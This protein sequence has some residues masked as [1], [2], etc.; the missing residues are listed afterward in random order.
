MS[1]TTRAARR[2]EPA[3]TGRT[4]APAASTYPA[5]RRSQGGNRYQEELTPV[6]RR[7]KRDDNLFRKKVVAAT[8][9]QATYRGKKARAAARRREG[10]AAVTCGE[11]ASRLQPQLT[12]AVAIVVALQWDQA[13]VY[14]L[15]AGTFTDHAPGLVATNAVG[16][17]LYV[18]LL[19]LVIAAVRAGYNARALALIK[20]ALQ[21]LVGWMWRLVVETTDANIG[22]LHLTHLSPANAMWTRFGIV[23]GFA[24]VVA[25][26]LTA[27]LT[28]ILHPARMRPGTSFAKEFAT[29]LLGAGALTI[30]FA[31]HLALVNF[32]LAMVEEGL[33][34]E[35]TR[36]NFDGY[37]LAA[38]VCRAVLV[39]VL[40]G[41]LKAYTPFAHAAR[42]AKPPTQK[43][44]FASSFRERSIFTGA[45]ALLWLVAFSWFA[46]VE[47][48]ADLVALEED[49]WGSYAVHTA[50]ALFFLLCAL[51]LAWRG[52]AVPK[53][54]GAIKPFGATEV[55]LYA[56]NPMLLG[57]GLFSSYTALV[58]RLA[59]PSLG[60]IVFWSLGAAL[61][62]LMWIVILAS[63][64]LSRRGG[65]P[66]TD[67]TGLTAPG[68]AA[69]G[70]RGAP[71]P[72]QAPPSR[73]PTA[74]PATPSYRQPY[75]GRTATPSGYGAGGG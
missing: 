36:D 64:A 60:G 26:L 40:A 27:L 30:G 44:T 42:V 68:A 35:P 70:K 23:A 47:R 74:S 58:L 51:A 25:P 65:A 43:E 7:A 5:A 31:W 55:L 71:A 72:A 48:L 11:F 54:C 67:A 56:A 38:S 6:Q 29:L 33:A 75:A 10:A 28:A 20:L 45:Y 62:V 4:P 32:S 22:E 15:A 39:S 9:L 63:F 37:S 52:S 24:L 21:V 34:S 8:R 53:C 19:T 16:T 2:A 49:G 13:V 61:M 41:L 17:T 57:F 3:R 73:Q 46:V 66:A 1:S 18:A 50:F 69:G 12:T 59:T 14:Q